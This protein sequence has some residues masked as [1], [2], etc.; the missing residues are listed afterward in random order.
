[1]KISFLTDGR[2]WRWRRLRTKGVL[3]FTLV[4]LIVTMAVLVLMLVMLAQLLGLTLQASSASNQKMDATKSARK[5]LDAVSNDL[6]YAVASGQT[7]I[8]YGTA[9]P[10]TDATLAMLSRGR[11]PAGAEQSGR[12]LSIRYSLEN[13]SLRRDYLTVPWSETKLFD[14]A[15]SSAQGT[16]SQVA[17]GILRFAVLAG[18]EDGT[19]LPVNE[20]GPAAALPAGE[21]YAGEEVPEDW[22]ALVAAKP[23]ATAVV[24]ALNARIRSLILAVATVD[25]ANLRLMAQAGALNILQPPVTADP[26]KEWEA[27]LAAATNVPAPARAAIRFQL[28][29]IPL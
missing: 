18:L 23:P 12:M 15:L 8:L 20:L 1:M 11:A 5:A 2:F 7:S 26:V 22:V 3:A 27:Q 17:S 13:N 16:Q 28:V 24:T 14:A 29:F 10:A 25:E 9:A 19:I 21:L 4:E 6:S